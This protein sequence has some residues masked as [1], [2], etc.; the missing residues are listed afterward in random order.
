MKTSKTLT[1]DQRDRMANALDCAAVALTQKKHTALSLCVLGESVKSV[2][3]ALL[4]FRAALTAEE[5]AEYNKIK[6]NVNRIIHGQS[7]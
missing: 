3:D 6:G 1:D 2:A 5:S 4:L 7:H